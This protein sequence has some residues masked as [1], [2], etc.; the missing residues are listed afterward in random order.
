MRPPARAP[1]TARASSSCRLLAARAAERPSDFPQQSHLGRR[2]R[3][4]NAERR[5]LVLVVQLL[6]Q[7]TS[8]LQPFDPRLPESDL[9]F[10]RKRRHQSRPA[11]TG[12][13]LVAQPPVVRQAAEAGLLV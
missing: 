5:S 1:P 10:G 12:R 3:A 6:E 4:A 9:G 2:S 13:R 8:I 7:L 11:A